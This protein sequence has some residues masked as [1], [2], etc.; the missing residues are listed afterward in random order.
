MNRHYFLISC[1]VQGKYYVN[2]FSSIPGRGYESS[3]STFFSWAQE[4]NFGSNAC[5]SL[6]LVKGSEKLTCTCAF[7]S[8]DQ[9]NSNHK[10]SMTC[11]GST[12]YTVSWI[13]NMTYDAYSSLEN[14]IVAYSMENH[15][16]AGYKSMIYDGKGNHMIY[17]VG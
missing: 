2:N 8:K 17:D 9:G 15:I 1:F 7:C 14:H 13:E 3:F 6:T 16:F 12:S 11:R 5:R 10:V 4:S